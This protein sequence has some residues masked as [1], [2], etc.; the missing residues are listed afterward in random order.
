[1]FHRGLLAKAKSAIYVCLVLFCVDGSS[2]KQDNSTVKVQSD[3]TIVADA[4]FVPSKGTVM[5][6]IVVFNYLHFFQSIN[7][8]IK[9]FSTWPK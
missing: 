1:M 9:Q 3:E 6:S 5:N 7:Q 4:T 2:G 8:S